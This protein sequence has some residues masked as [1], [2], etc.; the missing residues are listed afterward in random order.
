MNL[1]KRELKGDVKFNFYI[2]IHTTFESQEERIESLCGVPIQA[3]LR[4]TGSFQE[5]Q[6]ERIERIPVTQ[7][8]ITP[9]DDS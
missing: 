4:A 7:T 1:R 3:S 2:H 8:G 5:S 9:W 6:E